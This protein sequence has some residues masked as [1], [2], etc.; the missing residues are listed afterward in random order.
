MD[1]L[2][3][4]EEAGDGEKKED[5]VVIKGHTGSKQSGCGQPQIP[6]CEGIRHAEYNPE[7]FR[8]SPCSQA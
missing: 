7:S 6:A 4:D 1:Y 5:I 3:D 2:V 8:K